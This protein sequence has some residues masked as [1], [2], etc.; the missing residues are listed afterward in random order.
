MLSNTEVIKNLPIKEFAAG[1]TLIMEGGLPGVLYFLKTG[2]VEILKNGVPITKVKESGAVFGEMSVLLDSVH[3]A[4]VRVMVDSTFYAVDEPSE[5]LKE[6]PGIA[7]YVATILARRI[8]ALNK[9]LVDVKSQLKE[10]TGNVWL[11]D[12]VLEA[13]MAKHFEARDVAPD[14]I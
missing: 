11:V 7:A 13:I 6:Y 10:Q 9:Y 14:Q 4:T 3:T 5:F 8:D 12:E 1:E 2:A